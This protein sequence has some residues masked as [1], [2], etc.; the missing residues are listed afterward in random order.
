MTTMKTPAKITPAQAR[1][2][3]ARH[4]LWARIGQGK[5]KSTSMVSRFRKDLEAAYG[6][7][8][9]GESARE[10]A[11]EACR[12]RDGK[13]EDMAARYAVAA[14]VVKGLEVEV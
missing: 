6:L 13:F 2:T 10:V 5:Y 3:A 4:M 8:N 7:E 12:T 11:F 14:K 1:M 9:Y